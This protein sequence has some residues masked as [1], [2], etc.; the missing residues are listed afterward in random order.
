[1]FLHFE[2]AFDSIERNF[3][4]KTLKQSNFGDNFIDG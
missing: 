2:K 3:L 1:M 4:S